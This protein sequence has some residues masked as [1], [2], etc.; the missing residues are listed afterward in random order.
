MSNYRPSN[1]KF[2]IVT[3]ITL[4]GSAFVAAGFVVPSVQGYA[5]SESTRYT[6]AAINGQGS[7]AALDYRLAALLDSHNEAAAVG[8]ARVYLAQG[9]SEEAMS[10][11][12]RV[13]ENQDGLR[14]RTQTLTELGKYDRAK[15]VADK[16]FAHG[17]EG[18]VL[19]AAAVYKLGDYKPELAAMD[20]HLTSVEALQA[21]ARLRA[22]EITEAVEL[23]VLGL[24]VSSSALLVK[25]PAS[26]PRNLALGESL[27]ANGDKESL[28]MSA[29]YLTA[30]INLDPSD[31]E[32]R[33]TYGNV[34]RAQ[35]KVSE[36]D[37][38]DKLVLRLRQGK[39]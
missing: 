18:D 25:L 33:V 7:E 4:A 2:Y 8:L 9:R 32:L 26:V 3:T 24:P 22:G 30:G 16:L 28:S 29:D 37:A 5:K 10:L 35:K 23:R 14:L 21:L 19:L 15:P 31:I 13:G 34:L 39:L 17:N 38:Q 12:E 11:L 1:T 20:S 6:V 27:L 36:A